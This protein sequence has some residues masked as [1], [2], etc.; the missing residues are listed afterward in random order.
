ME[1]SVRESVWIGSYRH[2]GHVFLRQFKTFFFKAKLVNSIVIN[3]PGKLFLSSRTL[4]VC[5]FQTSSG[6]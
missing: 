1:T 2:A 3:V 6:S 5:K 4:L